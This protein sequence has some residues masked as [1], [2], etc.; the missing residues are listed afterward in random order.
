VNF[1]FNAIIYHRRKMGVT[2]ILPLT[3]TKQL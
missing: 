2:W 1:K 3:V